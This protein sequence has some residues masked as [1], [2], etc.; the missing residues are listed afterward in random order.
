MP[1]LEIKY[2]NVI[3]I[4]GNILFCRGSL[5]MVWSICFTASVGI[6]GIYDFMI[7]FSCRVE[8][9]LGMELFSMV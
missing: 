2:W 1:V 9:L 5:E 8:F 4:K 6:Y 3:Q 7:I